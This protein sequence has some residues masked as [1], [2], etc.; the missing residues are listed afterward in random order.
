MKINPRNIEVVDKK[1]LEI[2]R[3][4]DGAEK[5]FIAAQM[6]ETARA[7]VEANIVS[8]HPEWTEAQIS[9]ALNR[10]FGHGPG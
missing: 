8:T 6:F 3:Q 9:Q 4:K 7:I 1:T 10:R 2:L 5:M